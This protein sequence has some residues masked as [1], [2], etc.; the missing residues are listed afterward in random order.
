MQ[1]VGGRSTT[2]PRCGGDA[3]EQAPSLAGV[4]KRTLVEQ[5]AGLGHGPPRGAPALPR[6]QLRDVPRGTAA[7]MPMSGGGAAA[8]QRKAANQTTT[9]DGLPDPAP[10][11]TIAPPAGE[12]HLDAEGNPIVEHGGHWHLAEPPK[13]LRFP[14]AGGY[15]YE[16]LP[17]SPNASYA[18]LRRRIVAIGADQLACADALRG[19][20]KYWFAKV[21]YFVTTHELAAIDAGVYLYPHMKMQEVVHFH[22]AYQANLDAW[23]AGNKDTVEAHWKKA[24]ATAESEQGGTWYKPGSI[25][26]MRALLPSMQ[27]HI[28]FDLPRAL[29]TCFVLHYAGIPG[30]SMADFRADFEAMAPVFDQAQASLLAEVKDDTWIVDPGRYGPVQDGGFPFLFSVPMERQ[31]TFEKASRLAGSMRSGRTNGEYARTMRRQITSMHPSSGDDDFSV[32]GSDIG[33]QFDWMNQPGAIRDKSAPAAIHEAA[34]PPP[35]FPSKLYFKQGRGQGDDKL[36]H[37]I[38]DDQ[39]LAPFKALAEWTR[40][41][42]DAEIYLEGHASAEGDEIDNASLASNRAFLVKFFLWRCG[43][44]TDHNRF[45]EIS[46]GESRASIG[47]EWRYVAVKITTSG[48][49][50]QQHHSV[51]ANLPSEV[52]SEPRIR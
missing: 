39:D 15:K 34:P 48:T 12:P 43:A 28:R 23:R 29:A 18:A 22:A 30:T 51:N 1:K 7:S 41:V 26:L 40:K 21:Y 8:V 5:T 11:D 31:H 10:P 13:S 47:P 24:F 42:R 33:N 25:E 46:K 37:A 14:I 44:D 4:G 20:M 38:R 50:R 36:E 32:D 19:D 9:P 35:S 16:L 45:I 52:I 27:A 49:G 3:G 6:I 2:S 17:I